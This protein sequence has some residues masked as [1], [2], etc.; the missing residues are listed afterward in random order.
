ML[1]G[2]WE[3]GNL[4]REIFTVIPWLS[5]ILNEIYEDCKTNKEI[6]INAPIILSGTDVIKGNGKAVIICVGER[7]TKGKI[8]RMVDNSKDEKVTPL[9][10][11]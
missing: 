8:R 3:L 7:S 11:K 6:K 4:L 1:N 2:D 10:E 9:Q 5:G